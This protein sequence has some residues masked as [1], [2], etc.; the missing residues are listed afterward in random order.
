MS[1]AARIL[2]VEDDEPLRESMIGLISMYAPVD[3][4]ASFSQARTMFDP[5]RHR[6]VITDD[7]LGDGY[8]TDLAAQIKADHPDVHVLL[9]SGAYTERSAREAQQA[10]GA[11]HAMPKGARSS[12]VAL[13]FID[14]LGLSN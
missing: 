3:A 2:L 5:S 14:D 1:G 8:G 9:W 11:D 4:A 13:G 10:T 6:L 12:Q 7:D